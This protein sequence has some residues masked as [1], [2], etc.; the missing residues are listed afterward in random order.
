MKDTVDSGG[1]INPEPNAANAG[2]TLKQ[3][4]EEDSAIK[5]DVA[6]GVATP[7]P[8]AAKDEEAEGHNDYDQ[9]LDY[10]E[11]SEGL[12]IK[13]NVVEEVAPRPASASQDGEEGKA[14]GDVDYYHGTV[15]EGLAIEGSVDQEV[16]VEGGMEQEDADYDEGEVAGHA[17]AH[18]VEGKWGEEALVEGTVSPPV[19]DHAIRPIDAAEAKVQIGSA[20]EDE[21]VEEVPSLDMEGKGDDDS[22][23]T[24]AR[25]ADLPEH[26]EEIVAL[27]VLGQEVVEVGNVSEEGEDYGEGSEGKV[28]GDSTEGESVD[29]GESLAIEGDG[30]GGESIPEVTAEVE[31]SG[32]AGEVVVDENSGDA[33]EEVADENEGLAHVN[34]EDGGVG[35][36]HGRA[37]SGLNEQGAESSDALAESPGEHA[38]LGEGEKAEEMNEREQGG[39]GALVPPGEVLGEEVEEESFAQGGHAAEGHGVPV[40]LHDGQGAGAGAGEMNSIG[41]VEGEGNA[42][43]GPDGGAGDSAGAGAGDDKGEGGEG[44]AVVPAAEM[45]HCDAQKDCSGHG[46]CIEVEG[47]AVCRC[48]APWAGHDCSSDLC[49]RYVTCG[50]CSA[51]NTLPT[52][53]EC[54]WSG[55]HC[56]AAASPRDMQFTCA[57]NSST[58]STGVIMAMLFVGAMFAALWKRRGLSPADVSRDLHQGGQYEQVATAGGG[59]ADEEDWDDWDDLPPVRSS[60]GAADDC[61]AG[62]CGGD[63]EMTAAVAASRRG[64]TTKANGNQHSAIGTFSNGSGGPGAHAPTSPGVGALAGAKTKTGMV[65]AA[66]ARGGSGSSTDNRNGSSSAG[67]ARVSRG[68]SLEQP[69]SMSDDDLFSDMGIAAQPTFSAQRAV[70][71]EAQASNPQRSTSFRE[72][73]LAPDVDETVDEGAWDEWGGTDLDIDV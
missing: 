13:G 3:E 56:R 8:T 73:A 4:E 21:G 22:G 59:A 68:N 43:G 18:D 34:Q 6:T 65:L 52:K 69:P 36:G 45:V 40:Q 72:G 16:G 71:P 23:S 37:P 50:E 32:D 46:E 17:G 54:S 51:A 20:E 70:V 27:D 1:G 62:R 49:N 57:E 66:T 11:E 41:R 64:S 58:G 25:P 55:T 26:D 7:S 33:A 53:M 39:M 2:S 48:S 63:L 9:V 35:A 67:G 47:Q 5:G 12:A 24:D 30:A 15:D 10:G 61:E 31:N 29:A 42:L 19:E 44:A 14:G 38:V 60:S 28:P